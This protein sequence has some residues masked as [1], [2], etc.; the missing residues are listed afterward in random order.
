MKAPAFWHHRSL[1]G[2]IL[3]PLSWLYYGLTMLRHLWVTPQSAPLPVICVGN[4]I[5]GGAGK[6][7]TA[8]ALADLLISAGYSPHFAS[9]GYGGNLR[10]ASP[11]RVNPSQH[12]AAEMGDEPLLLAAKAPCWVGRDRIAAAHAASQAGAD[13]LILDDGLQNPSMKKDLTLLVI[14]GPYGHGNG[15][16]IPAGPMRQPLPAALR[17][18]DAVVMIGEDKHTFTPTLPTTLPPSLSKDKPIWQAELVLKLP[19]SLEAQKE[20]VAFCGIG[21]P[22]KF[23]DACRQ[24]GLSLH[25]TQ[26]FPDH[27][28][29]SDADMQKILSFRKRNNMP[30]V[31]TEKDYVRIPEAYLKEI[32]AIPATL[33]F[34]G[35]E[36][37]TNWLK[38]RLA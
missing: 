8:L 27:H 38:A 34:A 13:L 28:P 31:T 36:P 32:I 10:K 18:S 2:A 21:R 3:Y 6:T 24:T 37:F 9:R 12:T 35:E 15:W 22:Q 5:A 7:P 17:Q 26:S 33:K 25:A 29:Y 16:M 14:D 20:V 11:I 4:A 1:F 19:E 30:I 23:F